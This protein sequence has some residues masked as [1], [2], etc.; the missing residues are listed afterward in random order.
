MHALER[1]WRRLRIHLR[2]HAWFYGIAG[3]FLL[4]YLV[5][6][7]FSYRKLMFP[8]LDLGLFNRHMWGMVR[9]D[10]GPNTLKLP[11]ELNLLG[12]HSHFI[13]L[14]LTPFYSLY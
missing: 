2:G 7:Y 5:F 13:L 10:F 9:G 11:T 4:V 6:S 3:F 14:L 12:D 1:A 8:M